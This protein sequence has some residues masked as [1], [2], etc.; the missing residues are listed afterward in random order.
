M[1]LRGFSQD[2]QFDPAPPTHPPALTV[3]RRP[4]SIR[5]KRVVPVF[6]KITSKH[7]KSDNLTFPPPDEPESKISGSAKTRIVFD[8]INLE[9]TVISQKFAGNFKI[10]GK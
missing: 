6:Q 4:Y 1:N 3:K 9:E 8:M 7:Q 5:Q 2:L 10:F